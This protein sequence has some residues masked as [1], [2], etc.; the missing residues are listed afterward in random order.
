VAQPAL[1][2]RIGRFGPV[3]A[4]SSGIAVS[5]SASQARGVPEE[6]GDID[7]HQVEEL[8]VLVR[9]KLEVIHVLGMRLQ[10]ERLQAPVYAAFQRAPLIPRKVD[11]TCLAQELEQTLEVGV[12]VARVHR[13]LRIRS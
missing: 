5:R 3:A 13:A 12:D 10:P 2:T 6:A 7:E 8:G 11:P 1:H 9:V 4:R